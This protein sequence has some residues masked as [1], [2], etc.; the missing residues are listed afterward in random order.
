[1]TLGN[2]DDKFHVFVTYIFLEDAFKVAEKKQTPVRAKLL[3]PSKF[4]PTGP[5]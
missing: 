2:N 3:P 1:M 5:C 4:D